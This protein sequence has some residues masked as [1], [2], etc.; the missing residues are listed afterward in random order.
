MAPPESPQPL[1]DQAARWDARHAADGHG[2][3]PQPNP[4]IQ[5]IAGALTPGRAIDVAAGTGR[6][7]LWLASR[8]WT[9]RAIDFSPVAIEIG[10]AAAADQGLADRMEWVEADV[11]ALE[12]EPRS[13]DL[14]LLAFLHLEPTPWRA[15]L[16]EAADAVTA[17]GALL[18]VGHDITNLGTGAPG[19]A[20]PKVLHLEPTPWRAVLSEA[21]DAVTAGGALLVVGHDI[22]NLGTGAPGPAEPKV[23]YSVAALARDLQRCG[24]RIEL[25]EVRQRPSDRSGQ[26]GE[27]QAADTVLFARRA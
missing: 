27:V 4:W 16:S 18:V 8:G 15:V 6:H 12:L 22:T 24:M 10:R 14:V 7:A 23:L 2:C 1:D 13:A 3:A 9:V 11:T 19:P 17:G 26:P 25:A 20:E 21:A 5:E